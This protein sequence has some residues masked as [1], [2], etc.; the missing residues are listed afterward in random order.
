MKT[1]RRI[2]G[3]LTLALLLFFTGCGPSGDKAPVSDTTAVADNTVAEYAPVQPDETNRVDIGR[4]HEMTWKDFDAQ[5]TDFAQSDPPVVRVYGICDSVTVV[6]PESVPD[7][8]PEILICD[9]DGVYTVEDAFSMLGIEIGEVTGS[10]GP[11]IS[12]A[13]LDDRFIGLKFRSVAEHADRTT[14]LL[15]Q[16]TR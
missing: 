2:A 11:W 5:F 16:F 3:A 8:L 4:W 10:E 15:L 7:A 1:Q 6:F 9:L 13:S 12:L 14:Q